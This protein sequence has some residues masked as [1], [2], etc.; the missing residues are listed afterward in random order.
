MT[1]QDFEQSNDRLEA[2]VPVPGEG[3]QPL[4]AYRGVTDGTPL[5]ISCWRPTA[6]ELAE[7]HRTGHVW[8]LV[9]GQDHPVVHL[10]GESPFGPPVISHESSNGD[11]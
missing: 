3:M 7:I 2:L 5:M 9:F 10:A 6:E 11:G 8:L 1:P 4:P